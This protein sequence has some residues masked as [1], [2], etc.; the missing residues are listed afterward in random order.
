MD[1][2]LK[3]KFFMMDVR[4]KITCLILYNSLNKFIYKSKILNCKK[5]KTVTIIA[6]LANAFF[7]YAVY[8]I[9]TIKSISEF[10]NIGNIGNKLMPLYGNK[11]FM[12]SVILCSL[13]SFLSVNFNINSIRSEYEEKYSKKSLDLSKDKKTSIIIAYINPIMSLLTPMLFSIL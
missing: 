1:K 6:L 9:N 5:Q 8:D 2:I 11:Y 10:F 12:F 13:A 4:E 7:I 3:F